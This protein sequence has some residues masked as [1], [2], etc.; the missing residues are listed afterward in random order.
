MVIYLYKGTNSCDSLKCGIHQ[1]CDI[2][3]Y[4]I[5]TCI[6]PLLCPL[7]LDS[8]CGSD[9]IT[10][11][12]E[13]VLRRESCLRQK[14]VTMIYKGQ[15]GK[16]HL[17]FFELN[18]KFWQFLGKD[19]VCEG[20]KCE[21]GAICTVNVTTSKPFCDCPSCEEEY[22]PVCG[23]DSV[24]YTNECKLKRSACEQQKN[25]HIIHYGFCCKF[26]NF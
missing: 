15:C 24:S 5:A 26:F 16:L 23:S 3:R 2:D 20:F 17:F 8:V 19:G 4:G 13:C 10:Y 9:G 7:K 12:S 1:E 11:D 18:F 22:K 6:C 21:F 14:N 25:I